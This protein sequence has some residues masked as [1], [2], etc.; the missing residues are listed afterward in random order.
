M[1]HHNI[2]STYS[3][4]K[5]ERRLCLGY[6]RILNEFGILKLN[7]ELK[8]LYIQTRKLC[9]VAVRTL[10][11]RKYIEKCISNLHHKMWD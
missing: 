6:E 8:F 5:F 4:C 1:Q 2:A 7:V 3:V 9:W 11:S 10:T